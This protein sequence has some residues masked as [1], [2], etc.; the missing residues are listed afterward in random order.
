MPDKMD[1]MLIAKIDSLLEAAMMSIDQCRAALMMLANDPALS[2]T[3]R[4]RLLRAATN[5]TYRSGRWFNRDGNVFPPFS[6]GQAPSQSPPPVEERGL[7]PERALGP[8]TQDV[9]PPP[10]PPAPV[11]EY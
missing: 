3:A 10:I 6:A 7:E 9:Q 2:S 1:D 11:A 5:P 8:D 4:D